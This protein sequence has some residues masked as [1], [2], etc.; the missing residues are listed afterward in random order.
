MV[1]TSPQTIN[2][3]SYPA[4]TWMDVAMIANATIGSAHI[5]NASIT[6]AKI[7]DAAIT[8]AKIYNLNAG[9]IN[10]GTLDAARIGAKSI[11]ADKL[12]VNELSAISAN[13]GT[14]VAYA[15]INNKGGQ[16][17]VLTGSGMK[18]YYPNGQMAI[19]IG[20]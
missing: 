17:T 16:R 2:G 6:T 4:G 19:K 14:M 8:D 20:F 13:L 11:T 18:V 12:E 9:K 15:D 1:L 10:A 7:Q 3:V 5:A